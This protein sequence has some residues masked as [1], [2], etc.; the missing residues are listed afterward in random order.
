MYK[1]RSIIRSCE[2]NAHL[3]YSNERGEEKKKKNCQR[4][5]ACIYTS[6]DNYPTLHYSVSIHIVCTY[7][8]EL[9]LRS[10]LL[11][12]AIFFINIRIIKSCA[13]YANGLTA[14]SE[15]TKH[16]HGCK[17]QTNLEKFTFGK[18]AKKIKRTMNGVKHGAYQK[19]KKKKKVQ[20]KKKKKNHG[21][22]ASPPP[23]SLQDGNAPIGVS[24]LR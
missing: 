8:P 3:P 15:L 14:S 9:A 21:F 4:E 16:R 17:M 20:K 22:F 19:K 12:N 5:E 10:V 23:Q 7:Q 13:S 11:I 18:I 24:K 6:S 1:T 2:K